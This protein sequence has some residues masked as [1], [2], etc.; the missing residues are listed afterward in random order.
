MYWYE[1]YQMFDNLNRAI[2]EYV[3]SNTEITIYGG[4]PF[5]YDKQYKVK[6][7]D[8]FK[9]AQHHLGQLKLSYYNRLKTENV[10]KA[11]DNELKDII[12]EFVNNKFTYSL[13]T[14]EGEKV[15][16]F[17][18]LDVLY[19]DL[20]SGKIKGEAHTSQTFFLLCSYIYYWRWLHEQNPLHIDISIHRKV[21]APTGEGVFSQYGTVHQPDEELVLDIILT[22]WNEPFK[23][24]QE[25]QLY[26][27]S[28][29][30]SN[31]KTWVFFVRDK[32]YKYFQVGDIRYKK[33]L[34][35]HID[36][37]KR[38]LDDL[39]IFYTQFMGYLDD[40]YGASSIH[41]T[42]EP[43]MT[44]NNTPSPKLIWNGNNNTL[45][46]I[47]HQL[48]MMHITKGGKTLP[49]LDNTYEEIALFLKNNFA[50][51]SNTTT[52]TIETTLSKEDLKPQKS[53]GKITL[54]QG[55]KES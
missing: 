15:L 9:H 2:N 8:L 3:F 30:E 5:A 13:T 43:T 40:V 7:N 32:A 38:T 16:L 1:H 22:K 42:N 12:K 21:N 10:Y 25:L 44:N 46:D 4:Y 23:T 36:H 27:N 49:Y 11:I 20:E 26:L 28:L 19:S 18:E 54:I 45:I 53:T 50:V 39:K 48:K 31:R 17:Y 55:F 14:N 52:K 33:N 29:E 37:S 51:F 47:F 41:K 24:F 34:V 6:T 35:P